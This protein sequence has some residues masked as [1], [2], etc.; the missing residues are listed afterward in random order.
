MAVASSVQ[1]PLIIFPSQPVIKAVSHFYE[2]KKRELSN[3]YIPVSRG[4]Q[5]H[6]VERDRD[7]ARCVAPFNSRNLYRVSNF[8]VLLP[9]SLSLSLFV[10]NE[11]SSSLDSCVPNRILMPLPAATQ[12]L[13]QVL[14]ILN[15]TFDVNPS[16]NPTSAVQ[17]FTVGSDK[18]SFYSRYI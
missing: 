13:F 17:K 18:R 3:K 6:R 15:Q 4:Q 5:L 14:C 2:T 8:V 16:L 12:L 1:Q 10:H 9:L 7:A 11:E